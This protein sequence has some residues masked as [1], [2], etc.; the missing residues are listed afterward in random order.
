METPQKL[1]N[2]DDKK[3]KKVEEATGPMTDFQWNEYKKMV[4]IK[5]K[6]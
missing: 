2:L 6:Y 5:P 1:K 3:R 4:S